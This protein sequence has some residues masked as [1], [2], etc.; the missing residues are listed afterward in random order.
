M[1]KVKRP[2]SVAVI[3]WIIIAGNGFAFALGLVKTLRYIDSQAQWFS[4]NIDRTVAITALWMVVWMVVVGIRL[5]SGMAILKG[6]NWGRIL[7]VLTVPILIIFECLCQWLLGFPS[8][9]YLVFSFGISKII[10]PGIF[11]IVVLVYMTKPAASAFF[12]SGDFA[13]R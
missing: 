12:R 7:Y 1:G 10:V 2:K 11:A 8:I 13:E 3:A 4:G 9:S 6:L 5:V